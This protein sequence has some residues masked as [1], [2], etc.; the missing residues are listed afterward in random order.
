MAKAINQYELAQIVHGLLVD[1]E[2]LD[3]LCE[4]P[5]FERFVRAIATTVAD[6]CGGEIGGLDWV[7]TYSDEPTTDLL[8]AVRGNDALPRDGGIWQYFDPEGELEG[9]D[10]PESAPD[11]PADLLPKVLI[12][13]DGGLVHDV[14]SDHALDVLVIDRDLDGAAEE[15]IYALPDP[16]NLNATI[17]AYC[18]H[19][20]V[21]VVPDQ[22]RTVMQAV[23]A[24]PFSSLQPGDR[25]YRTY[26]HNA[27]ASG[28]V[29]IRKI[30]SPDGVIDSINTIV[31]CERDDGSVLHAV[32]SE[33]QMLGQSAD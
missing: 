30:F 4:R 8:F 22:V 25:V 24:A 7:D 28:E 33:L 20:E 5:Q 15:D 13:M 26:P 2:A 27:E 19:R 3:M 14:Y 32:A 16:A 29:T 21:H 17:G 11:W 12:D 9:I 31:L 10:P 23:R 6:H 18:S 1:P